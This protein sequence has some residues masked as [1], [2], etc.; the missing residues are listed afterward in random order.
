MSR[1]YPISLVNIQHLID[2][3][4]D[5]YPLVEKN[6]IA[7]VIRSFFECIRSI[8]I[9]KD[10]LS[11]SNLFTNSYIIFNLLNNIVAICPFFKK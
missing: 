8:L 3:V 10:Y 11:I 5:R 4:H 7:V 6:D 2:R 1:N 9:A